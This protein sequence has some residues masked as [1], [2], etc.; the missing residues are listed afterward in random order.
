MR[1]SLAASGPAYEALEADQVNPTH[2]IAL[3]LAIAQTRHVDVAL[4]PPAPFDLAE[5]LTTAKA[6][7][8]ADAEPTG[9]A[10]YIEHTLP[11]VLQ[12]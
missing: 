5:H 10:A 9:G 3:A 6:A 8:P 11:N 12:T 7:L 1:P 4:I 2:A